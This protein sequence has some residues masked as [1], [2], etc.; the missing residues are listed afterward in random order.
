M[1]KKK[2]AFK[3]AK[4]RIEH[5]LEMCSL[6]DFEY[7]MMKREDAINNLID[8]LNRKSMKSIPFSALKRENILEGSMFDISLE[9]MIMEFTRRALY[10]RG[11]QICEEKK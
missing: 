2:N 11:Y 8:L 5:G 6:E 1:S 10:D 4:K 9:T 7:V 3:E